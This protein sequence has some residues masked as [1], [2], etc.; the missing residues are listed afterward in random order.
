MFILGALGALG[1]LGA[2]VPVAVATQPPFAGGTPFPA[3]GATHAPAAGATH[4][5]AAGATPPCVGAGLR[6][7]AANSALTAAATLCL[8]NRIRAAHELPPLHA[9]AALTEVAASQVGAMV[10]SDYF[11]DIRP[12]GQTPL[13]LI[14]ASPYLVAGARLTVGENIAWGTGSFGRPRHIVREWMASPSHRA[15][16]LDASYRDAGVAIRPALPRVVG[17]G[18]SGATYAMEFCARL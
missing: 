9:N 17:A 15:I 13:S 7:T 1:P 18:R 14:D 11:A 3:A 2:L 8:V 16:I 4:A 10:S 5:P 12:T 6:P